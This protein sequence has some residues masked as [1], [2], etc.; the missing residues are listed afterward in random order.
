M[1]TGNGGFG[2]N[3]VAA[4]MTESEN[5]VTDAVTN[6]PNASGRSNVALSGTDLNADPL[7]VNAAGGDF[8]LTECTSPAIS[9]G[10]DLG[11][12][13]PDMNGAAG[14]L[15][16]GTAPDQ[17]A[18]ETDCSGLT[19][20]KRAFLTD[21]TAVT[22]SSTLAKGTLIKYLI[23][24]NNR[25]NGIN[26]ASVRDVL[27]AAF[28]YQAGTL[29]VDNSVAACAAAACTGV[30]EAAIY[31]AVDATAVKTDAV[32]ADVVSVAGATIDAGNQYIA[33]GQLN[34]AA[35]R[36]WALLFT[37]TLQ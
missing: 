5:D 9:A 19:L 35:T 2:I 34:L 33:N 12:D 22:D 24:I 1:V 18:Y 16:N 15:F 11:G 3:R 26:D 13:Q 17:G 4:S 32:D 7:Y 29:K 8:T 27:A 20:V 30:E 6:P 36:V 14:G 21:G 10:A 37:V 25:G 31:A 28:A 23:Y